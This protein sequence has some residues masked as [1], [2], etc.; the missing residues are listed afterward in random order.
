[1]GDVDDILQPVG[2]GGEGGNDD[3]LVAVLEL[4]L[5]PGGHQG[6][7]GGV[8][9][10]LHVGGVA[11]QGQYAL[12][13]QLAQAAQVGDALR[14]RGVDLEVAGHHHGAHGGLDGKGHGVGDGVVHMDK[15]HLEAAG[16]DDLPGLMGEQLDLVGQV[17]FLQLPLHQPQSQPGAVDRNPQILH[18]VG[19]AADVVLMAVGDKKAPQLVLVLDQIRGIGD[20]RIDAVHVVL[21]EAHAAIDHDH[22]PAV[23]QHGDIFADLI[24]AAQRNNFQ[25]FA[26]KISLR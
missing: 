19:N 16:L 11:Q 10:P 26:Q 14:G 1:M 12:L 21:G 6:L 7:R 2:V 20:D 24:E 22:I 15:L 25:F 17:E 18:Q 13:A 8:A 9:R 5:Q 4:P 3:P 23:F